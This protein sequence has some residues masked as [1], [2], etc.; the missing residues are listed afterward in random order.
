MTLG[1]NAQD[2]GVAK[3]RALEGVRVLDLSRILAGPTCTQLLGDLGAEVIKVER[4]GSGDDTRSWGPP[5]VTDRAGQPTDLSAYFLCANRNKQSIAVD[6]ANPAGVDIIRGLARVSD[7]VVENFKP[8]DLARRGLAYENLARDNPRLVWCSI[9]GFGHTGPYANRVGYDFVAQAMGGIMS[10]TG[11][12]AGEPQKVGIGISDVVCGLYAAAGILAA[13]RHRDRTG[14]GQFIDVS[15]YD[16]QISW[17]IN[18]AT[19][20]LVSG[21]QPR[22]LGNRHPN[23]APY[24]AFPASDG[25]LVIAV[26]NDGQFRRFCDVLGQSGLASD[27]RFLTNPDRV[28][29]VDALQEAV[30]PV[31]VGNTVAFWVDALNRAQVPAG[32]VASIPQALADPHSLARGAV[33]EMQQPEGVGEPLRLLGNPLKLS[34]TPVVYD[35][36]PPSLGQN[37]ACVLRDVLDLSGNKITE[38]AERGAFGSPAGTEGANA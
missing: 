33:I 15:L 4:P 3:A 20:H 31:L 10:I 12:P 9:T 16:T 28:G 36:S 19:N 37:T 32:P 25:H 1:D 2:Q 23:I 18:A 21:A 30:T 7:V 14:E 35:R 27:P 22:R 29:N 5:F 13:L 11:D 6:I 17:L 34:R 8:G 26:G 38:A 24:Q